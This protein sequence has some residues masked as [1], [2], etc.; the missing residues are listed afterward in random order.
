MHPLL[1]PPVLLDFFESDNDGLYTLMT[2]IA[3]AFAVVLIVMVTRA[4]RKSE[5]LRHAT[6]QAAAPKAGTDAPTS[7]GLPE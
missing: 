1:Y 4:S 7:G 3:V 5:A 6:R 2:L